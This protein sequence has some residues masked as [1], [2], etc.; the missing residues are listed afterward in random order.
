MLNWKSLWAVSNLWHAASLLE[1][2]YQIDIKQIVT[3]KRE[4][5]TTNWNAF[6]FP[7]YEVLIAYLPANMPKYIS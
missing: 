6:I 3:M 5:I 7:V 4:I 2:E 1:N